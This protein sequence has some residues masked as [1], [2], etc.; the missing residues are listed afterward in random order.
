MIEDMKFMMI[1]C[2]FNA[3]VQM[4]F[5]EEKY[6]FHLI[7]SRNLYAVMQKF[8]ISLIYKKKRFTLGR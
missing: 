4:K 6:P 1:Y 5:L 7:Y 2:K 8:H 3:T